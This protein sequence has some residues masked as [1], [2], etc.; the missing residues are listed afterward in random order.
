MVH[1]LQL[2]QSVIIEANSESLV[3]RHCINLHSMLCADSKDLHAAGLSL[4]GFP[5]HTV[6]VKYA[7]EHRCGVAVSGPGLTDAVS[8]TD[9]LRDGLPLQVTHAECIA[10]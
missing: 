4:P 8:G 2:Q 5:E 3:N 6:R 1:L 10:C 7:T 9:P